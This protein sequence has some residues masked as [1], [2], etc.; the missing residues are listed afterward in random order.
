MEGKG[1]PTDLKIKV[2]PEFIN[3]HGDEVAPGSDVVR[4]D[5]EDS[6][7]TLH[8]CS[9]SFHGFLVSRGDGRSLSIITHNPPFELTSVLAP[10]A[11]FFRFSSSFPLSTSCLPSLKLRTL[12]RSA[13]L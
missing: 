10:G 13:I 5:L 6:M 2:F 3:T 8:F 7:F 11:I 12:D 1:C 9:C 4:E